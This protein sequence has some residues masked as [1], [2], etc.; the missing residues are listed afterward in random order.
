MTSIAM[1]MMIA[2]ATIITAAVL[3]IDYGLGKRP[4]ERF[5]KRIGDLLVTRDCASTNSRMSGSRTSICT[6]VT[7]ACSKPASLNRARSVS[8]P[9]TSQDSRYFFAVASSM[10][11]A[12]ATPIDLLYAPALAQMQTR[13]LP[14]TRKARGLG[15][16]G[17]STLITSLSTMRIRSTWRSF[18]PIN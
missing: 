8:S 15:K 3:L 4:C 12:T 7:S 17:R 1:T 2:V 14:P 9:R 13:A 11:L 16:R 18:S 10:C 6:R 5:F